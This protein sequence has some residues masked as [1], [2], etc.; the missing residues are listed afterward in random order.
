MRRFPFVAMIMVGLPAIGHAQLVAQVGGASITQKDVLAANPA[1][2]KNP[3]ERNKTLLTLID[4]QA[5]LNA[6]AKSGIEKSPEYRKAVKQASA[7]L[8]IQLVAQQFSQSH[9]VSDQEAEA[10][11]KELIE[12][13]LPEQYRLRE[14]TT[15]SYQDAETVIAEI[16]AGK[17]F[18]MMAAEKSQ[19]LHTGPIGGETGWLAAPQLLAPI[20]KIVE[21]TKVGDVTGPIAVPNGFVVLQV[22]GKRETPKPDF[23]RIKSQLIAALRQEAWN[24]YVLKLRTEQ[25]AHLIVPLPEK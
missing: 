25:G 24:K 13:P 15:A 18:S 14:I 22:L 19:D 8:A 11:Y 10:K 23:A 3:A 4:R 16:K 20:L 7:N 12:K 2:A 5:V 9:P 21:K 6:A 1:A 17:S